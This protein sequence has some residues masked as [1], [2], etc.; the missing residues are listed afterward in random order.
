MIK[1]SRREFHVPMWHFQNYTRTELH[2][3][4]ITT[5]SNYTRQK[6]KP[7]FGFYFKKRNL[8]S[9]HLN[10]NLVGNDRIYFYAFIFYVSRMLLTLVLFYYHFHSQNRCRYYTTYYVKGL[11]ALKIKWLQQIFLTLLIL[12]CVNYVGVILSYT[13]LW[14]PNENIY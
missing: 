1:L 10:T 2:V 12:P 13:W 5:S 7:D 6:P 4:E 14:I 3:D 9:T 11:W 8:F